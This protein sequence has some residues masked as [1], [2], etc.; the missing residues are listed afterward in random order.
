M[1]YKN[2]QTNKISQNTKIKLKQNKKPNKHGNARQGGTS[3]R[4]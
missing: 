1:Q 3:R 2:K 4:D